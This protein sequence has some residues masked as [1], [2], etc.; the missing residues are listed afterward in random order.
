M[1]MDVAH[2]LDLFLPRFYASLDG[3]IFPDGDVADSFGILSSDR[4][5]GQTLA[6]A[7]TYVF[8]QT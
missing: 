2:A 5:W 8:V 7:D 1:G 4:K 3:Y 6:R